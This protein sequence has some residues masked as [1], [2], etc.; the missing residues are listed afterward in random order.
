MKV[1][2]GTRDFGGY[3]DHTW[4]SGDVTAV[5]L[6]HRV[7]VLGE[8][9]MEISP[10]LHHLVHVLLQGVFFTGQGSNLFQSIAKVNM[11]SITFSS[12]FVQMHTCY[13]IKIMFFFLV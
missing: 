9:E 7:S 6:S 13:K 5:H 11:N 8:G 10:F 2:N 12:A 4:F 3:T 1:S